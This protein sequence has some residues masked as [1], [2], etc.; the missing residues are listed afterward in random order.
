MPVHY[1]EV[2]RQYARYTDVAQ[3]I[4]S[5]DFYD[6]RPEHARS[7]SPPPKYDT[8]GVRQNTRDMRVREKLLEQR[9]DLI[10]WL[11]ARCPHL[12]R[13]P[14]DWRPQKKRR[15][16][17]IPLKEFPGYNFIG[18]VIGPRGNTQKRMQRETNTRIAIRG[19]GRGKGGAASSRD[20]APFV[21]AYALSRVRVVR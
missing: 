14:G 5:N 2:V 19:K 3:R 4:A 6:D 10:G 13:P 8:N 11:V 17:Y 7:P 12:F 21:H 9:S 18:L 16:L 15:K 20:I 1:A